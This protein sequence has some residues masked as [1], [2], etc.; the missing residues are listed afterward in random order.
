[1]MLEVEALGFSTD[2]WMLGE[3]AGIGFSVCIIVL[4]VVDCTF[5]QDQ[6]AS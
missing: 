2:T 1:M 3:N 4:N 6:R 5:I